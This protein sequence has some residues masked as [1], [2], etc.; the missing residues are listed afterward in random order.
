MT[1]PITCPI[2][3][4]EPPIILLLRRQV[5]LFEQLA[6]LS[7]QQAGLVGKG[8]A[9]ALLSLLARRQRFIDELTHLSAELEPFRVDWARTRSE[10]DQGHAA[11]A[12]ELV[13]RSQSLL[14]LILSSMY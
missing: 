13:E 12:D 10:L 5:A 7:E 1:E 2:S 9:E 3:N 14:D 4:V 11:S 8:P 6:K